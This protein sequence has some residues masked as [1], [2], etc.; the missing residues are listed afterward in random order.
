MPSLR[1]GLSAC[2][3]V[4]SACLYAPRTVNVYDPGCRIVTRQMVLDAEQ[5]GSIAHCRNEGCLTLLVAMGAVS[6]VSA[7][8]S[9][10][11]VVVGNV[12]YWF[13]KR[14]LCQPADVAAS[15]PP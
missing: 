3:L 13:E 15:A 9:G 5:V 7:V 6:A 12:V 4:L 10:S 1:W 14:S 2:P 11:V 8:V